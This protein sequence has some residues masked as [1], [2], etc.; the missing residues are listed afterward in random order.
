MLPAS[1]LDS[2]N[3]QETLR[4]RDEGEV[5]RVGGDPHG[6]GPHDG[7]SNIVLDLLLDVVRRLPL[8]NAQVR[9]EHYCED[10]VPDSLSKSRVSADAERGY[11]S[12]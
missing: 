5:D 12:G 11:E 7:G 1:H 2:V 10:G 9:E 6:P 4:R 3:V 8:R